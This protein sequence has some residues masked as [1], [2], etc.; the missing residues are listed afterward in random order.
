MSFTRNPHPLP[1]V[2]T[3]IARR[4]KLKGLATLKNGEAIHTAAGFGGNSNRAGA[5]ETYFYFS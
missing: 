2:S 4:T 3:V 5:F 1:V